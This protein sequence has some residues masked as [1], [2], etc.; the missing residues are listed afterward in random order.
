GGV[1]PQRNDSLLLDVG[2]PVTKWNGKYVKPLV[3]ALVLDHD[4]RVNYSAHGNTRG[5][6]GSHASG[7]GYG[8]WEVNLSPVFETRDAQAV[9]NGRGS[10][11]SRSGLANP[12]RYDRSFGPP[13]LPA[14]ALVNWDGTATGVP[15]RPDFATLTALR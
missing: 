10:A 1:G 9:V 3:A 5:S 15:S 4:G 8:P 12:Y 11:R 7:G 14:S 13:P 2:L 6:G